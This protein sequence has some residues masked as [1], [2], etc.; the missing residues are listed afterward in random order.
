MILPSAT[1]KCPAA[2]ALGT[3]T[4]SMSYISSAVWSSVQEAINSERL[5]GRKYSLS[6]ERRI[7]QTVL[8][9]DAASL[10]AGRRGRAEV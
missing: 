3:G 4:V 8:T 10:F 6:D 7:F 2:G 5:S 9:S 1:V